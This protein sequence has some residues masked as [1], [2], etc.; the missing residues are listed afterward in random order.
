[1]LD[2]IPNQKIIKINREKVDKV[3]GSGRNYLIAY[4]DNI[5]SAGFSLSG[6]AF[7][8]YIYLLFNRD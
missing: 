3:A 2:Y 1:M 7:K 8:V 6:S 5:L 4:Q